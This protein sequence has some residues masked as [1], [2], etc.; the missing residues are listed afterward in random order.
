MAEDTDSFASRWS[1]RKTLV[2]E[3]RAV[4]PAPVDAPVRPELVEGLPKT[5]T[6]SARTGEIA[7]EPVAHAEREPPPTLADVA[8]LNR[9]SN[10]ARFVAGDVAPEV[11]NA[12]L[13]KLF[14]DPH[15]NVMDGLD[16]YIDDYGKP[17]PLPL[18]MLRQMTQ[19][20]AL[21]LFDD[22]DKPQAAAASATPLIQ[23][24]SPTASQ[25]ASPTAAP[26]EDPALQLQP[27]HAAGCEST[28]PGAGEDPRREL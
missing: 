23:S 7:R 22:E 2:R 9:E 25:T 11:K 26:D 1:R 5:S 19:A 6:S 24:V 20:V 27:Q 14:S 21:G 13:K 12:A 8:G 4:P 17:D 3:G 16:T 18:S 28:Q 10:Y 15:F